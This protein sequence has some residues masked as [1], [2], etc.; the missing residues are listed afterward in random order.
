M[1]PLAR[2]FDPLDRVRDQYEVVWNGV[3]DGRDGEYLR[4]D[5]RLAEKRAGADVRRRLSGERHQIRLVP[6]LSVLSRAPSE[7]LYLGTIARRAELRSHQ[8]VG[9]FLDELIRLGHVERRERRSGSP[10]SRADRVI[11]EYRRKAKGSRQ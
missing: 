2:Q 3:R 10:W 8:E 4:A 5:L 11:V 1:S 6:V 9:R 7:W